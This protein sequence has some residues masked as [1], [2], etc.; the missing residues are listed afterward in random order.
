MLIGHMTNDND[1]D[2]T[3]ETRSFVNWCDDNFL[4]LNVDKTK[5]II[6]DFRK[7][8]TK[9][10]EI[11]LNNKIVERVHY[12]K[13]LGLV[14]DDELNWKE[15]VN[16]VLKKLSPRMYCL[17][18]LKSFDVNKQLLQMFYTSMI[19]SV[20]MFG[21]SS[22]GDNINK[23]DKNRLDKVIKK[24]SNVIG[25]KQSDFDTLLRQ[26]DTT[27]TKQIIHD[28]THPLHNEF[29]SRLIRRSGRYRLPR[30]KTDRY[31]RSYIPRSIKYL[32]NS[33]KR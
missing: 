16:T 11:S 28:Q 29:E 21:C 23:Q 9:P 26:R 24:A 22:W 1:T 15:N 30:S 18:K 13:Y 17:R 6:I 4:V 27:K 33:F 25:N 8:K 5:E 7:K 20:L 12:F 10:V 3:Y 32:N 2:F 14:I 31:Q 19:T